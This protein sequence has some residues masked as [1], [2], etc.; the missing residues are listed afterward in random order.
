MSCCA[1]GAELYLCQ[2]DRSGDEILLASR[3]VQDGVRQTDLSVPE[4]SCGACLHKIETALEKLA[5][6]RNA[7]ANLSTRRVTVL[8]S[9]DSPPP[10]LATLDALGYRAHL[11]DFS[12]DSRDPALSHLLRA[13]AVAGFASS[14]IM[15]LSVSVWSGADPETRELFH[16]LSALIA[17]PTLIYSGQV[18]FGSAWRSLRHGRTNMDVPISIGVLLTFG[19]SL[20]ETVQH[21]TYAYFDAAVTLLFFLL[22]G[23]TLD[24]VMRD[25]ARQAVSGLAK[26]SPRGA[27]VVRPDDTRTYLPLDEIEPG[28][29]ILLAAGERVPVSARVAEGNS[30]IDCSLVSG[31]SAPQ[32]A[33]EGTE[34]LAG[35]R[36]LTG[37]LI[38]VATATAKN[39]FLAEM[40]RMME[41]A[42]ASRSSYRRIADRAAR[43]YAPIV[44]TTALLSFIGWML[45]TGNAHQAI[46]IAIAVLIITCPCAL[47]LAVPM[48]HVV[49][50]RRLFDKG[51]MIRDGN[52]LERLAN[53]DAVIF[54]KTGTLTTGRPTIVAARGADDHALRIAASLAAHSQHPYSRALVGLADRGMTFDEVSECAGLGLEAHAG[55][56]VYRLGRSDWTIADPSARDEAETVV[57]SAD[58][59]RIAGFHVHDTL[60]RGVTQTFANLSA[61]GLGTAIVSG[62]NAKRVRDVAVPL[63]VSRIAG[64]RPADKVR[65]VD[66]IKASGKTV[67]MV[68]DGLNDAP[69][70]AA[71][72]VSMAPATAADI[73][74]NAA[75]LVFLHESLE[76]VPQGIEIARR[77][78]ALVRQNF[79]LAIAYNIVAIPVAVLGH[80]TPLIAAI[81]M[82]LSSILVVANALRLDYTAQPRSRRT[83]RGEASAPV[84][85]GSRQ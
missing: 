27:L 45:A 71:A 16:W 38:V 15:L 32:H 52:A 80:V 48:V 36:N 56:V 18:F 24:H 2:V 46:T 37:Q 54:D 72:D 82:S 28:M 9:G 33:F 77:A 1:P 30:A 78:K 70:L 81:A 51:I 8:W 5:C 29:T 60:R 63:G 44:H 35:T 42:E 84:M 83:G 59:R 85:I 49:A 47:G 66:E 20:Y 22:I 76:A 17:L 65:Y 3:V 50:A 11:Y 7:R 74:R 67:L 34:L 12:A 73:G 6:V 31:E 58:G 69:A 79:G 43:L 14:N 64:A 62:D 21:G 13:L 4:I 26:L 41:A 61:L 10:L 57:L 75:D 19:L 40:V 25:R 23:R 55:G 39:S 53:A 68:G